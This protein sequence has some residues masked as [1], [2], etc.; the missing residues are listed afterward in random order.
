M[1]IIGK[2]YAPDAFPAYLDGI[3]LVKW[4]PSLV[5]IHHTAF[6]SLADRPNGFT[7]VHMQNLRHY[8]GTQLK[9]SAGP[10]LFVDDRLIWVL[11]PLDRRGVHAVSFNRNSWAIEM[12]GNYDHESPTTGRGAQV[13]ANSA[14]ATAAMLRRLGLTTAAI[15]FHRDCTKTTKSCPGKL[16]QKSDFVQL[17]EN[18]L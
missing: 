12:L 2:G 8:Y 5:T 16:V 14:Q 17:V 6:P 11:S 10:H 15:R 4:K 13:L 9:W 18:Y 1:N 7:A 3:D